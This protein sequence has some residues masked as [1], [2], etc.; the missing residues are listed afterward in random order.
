MSTPPTFVAVTPTLVHRRSGTPSSGMFA[1]M[2]GLYADG[3]FKCAF[4]ERSNATCA[5][6]F[7]RASLSTASA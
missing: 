6:A 4:A 5:D 2:S 3:L 7:P 1:R